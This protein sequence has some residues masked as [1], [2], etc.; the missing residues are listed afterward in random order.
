MNSNNCPVCLTP[1]AKLANAGGGSGLKIVCPRCGAF[2]LGWQAEKQF[3]KEITQQQ[4]AILSGWI[5]K[6]QNCVITSQNIKKLLA[7]PTPPVRVKAEWLLR[8]LAQVYPNPGAIIDLSENVSLLLQAVASALDQKELLYLMRDYLHEEVGFL[9][10]SENAPK[11]GF[12]SY[13][14]SPKGWAYLDSQREENPR[15][16]IGFHVVQ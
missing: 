7:M 8:Y 11:H 3:C 6:H 2:K 5:R 1:K 10:V 9:H 4:R 14:I 16:E 12:E 13:K 15:R